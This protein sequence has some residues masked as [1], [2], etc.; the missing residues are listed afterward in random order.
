MVQSTSYGKAVMLGKDPDRQREIDQVLTII[1][2]CARA[3]IPAAHVSSLQSSA[4]GLR[5]LADGQGDI[6]EI[7]EGR[8]LKAEG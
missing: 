3:S 8:G 1:R 2:N 5:E 7:A 4:F 6:R